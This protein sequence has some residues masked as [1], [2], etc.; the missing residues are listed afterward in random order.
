MIARSGRY[1]KGENV[2]FVLSMQM[3][4]CLHKCSMHLISKY[5]LARDTY[6]AVASWQLENHKTDSH[7][8]KYH[9]QLAM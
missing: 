3:R 2:S 8:M 7:I 5:N 9:S 6:A 4:T 1:G